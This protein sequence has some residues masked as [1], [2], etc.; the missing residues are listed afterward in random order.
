MPS[1]AREDGVE[2]FWEE[3]GDGPCVVFSPSY[4]QH[5]GVFKGVLDELRKSHR[6]VRYDPRGSGESTRT[7]PYDMATDVNDL[8]AIAETV[9]PIAAVVGNGDG[10]NRAIH[11]AAKRPDL[12]PLVVSLETVPLGR[13]VADGTDALVASTGVLEALVGMMRAD[14]RSGLSAAV[15]RGNPGIDQDSLRERVD[16]TAAYIDHDAAT[17]RLEEWIA[18]NPG[19]DPETLGERL[20]VVFEGAGAWFPAELTERAQVLLPEARFVRVES[21]AITRPELTA[22]VIR[23]ATGA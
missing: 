11:A 20:L 5:P 10:S 19:D 12:I 14:Y 13:G 2:L 22:E 18:D 15:Q 3:S 23:G 21:G 7:G 6:V 1:V 8:I 9:A 4:I 17:T 16:L